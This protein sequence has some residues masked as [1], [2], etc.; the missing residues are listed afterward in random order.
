ML[1]SAYFGGRQP[2]TVALDV[3]ISTI[4]LLLPL[5]I[6]L[7][8]QDLLSREFDKRYYLNSLTY[9]RARSSLAFGR[10]VAVLSLVWGLLLVV[11]LLQVGLV[12][13]IGSFFSQAAPVALGGGYLIV[14]FFLSLDLLVLTTLAT[15]LAV[16]A[17]TP[18]F[19][20]IGTFGFMV[21]ARSYGAI[22]ELLSRDAGLVSNA[23]GYRA[24]LGV[25]GYLLPDLG[26][27]DVRMI[28]LYGKVDFLPADWPWLLASS[29]GYASALLALAI[30]ALQRKRF[31]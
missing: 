26:A 31:S 3:G 29:L 6:V 4:R 5:L 23:E 8:V 28:A 17:S 1:L 18:S 15:L 13:L 10:F 20:L 30:W 16:V 9:P 7:L 12:Q 27:L 11:G 25:L 19:V 14:M 2:V 21:V 22:V 24:G